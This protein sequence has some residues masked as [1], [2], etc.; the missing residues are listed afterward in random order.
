[1]RRAVTGELLK[2]SARAG[3]DGNGARGAKA[4]KID[5]IEDDLDALGGDAV[6]RHQA[7][8]A[9]VV[10]R[11]VAADPGKRHRFVRPA[12]PAMT[13]ADGRHPGKRQQ[14]GQRLEAVMAVNDV[15]R[16]GNVREVIDDGDRVASDLRRK[17]TETGTVD[18]G[19]MA[20]PQQSQREVPDVQLGAGA[21]R[22]DAVGE[23]NT[24]RRVKR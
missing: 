1:M 18:D 11:E 2:I 23:Q 8:P 7:I 3:R 9:R 14:R 13:D 16:L 20:A 19:Q 21:L 5:P 4:A 6:L 15:G 12:Y 22:K 24:Q 10:H 17:R